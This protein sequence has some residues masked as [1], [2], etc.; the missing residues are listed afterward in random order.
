MTNGNPLVGVAAVLLLAGGA[1]A[2]SVSVPGDFATIQEAIDAAAAGDADTILISNGHYR[3]NLVLETAGI[4]LKA[5]GKKVFVD[6]AYQ[7]NV[8]EVTADD[9]TLNG[10]I[11]VNGGPDE[12]GDPPPPEGD[13]D[14]GGVLITGAGALVQRCEFR[15][16]VDFG[17][18]LVGTGTI[19]DNLIVATLGP[20]LV[21]DSGDSGGP[22]TTVEDNDILRN[23]SGVEALK[24]PFVF[25][26]NTIS[27][28]T[29][30][31]LSVSILSADGSGPG[32]DSTKIKKNQLTGNGATA[33]LLV[34]EIGSTTLIEKNNIDENGTGMD[35]SADGLTVSKND[36][37]Q[38]TMVGAWL[39]VS[40]MTWDD[41]KMRRST[42]AGAVVQTAP[43][44]T[45]GNNTF[46]DSHFQ[47]SGGDGVIVE[48]S[49]NVFDDCLFSDNQG[50]GFSIVG[51][52]AGNQVLDSQA[53]DNGH[54]GFDNSGTDTLFKDNKSKGNLGADL[55]GIGDGT[56]TVDAASA[57]NTVSDESG[58]EAEQELELDTLA[59]LP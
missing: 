57:G 14:T 26:K 49:L 13:S 20:G 27:N 54:D 4:T 47:T 56:G 36:I 11:F 42:I 46:S 52:A 40:N 16:N 22:L 24:G 6:G 35:L 48:S 53:R 39:R 18:K 15:A 5:T 2:Q 7:G 58:L 33:L 41:N 29:G 55:A 31:G 32:A 38:S 17:L 37:D 8:L 43:G 21:L 3:E 44:V 34:D 30:D 23:A 45:D 1:Y 25:E 10:I 19:E 9:V 50:D 28:N 12:G 51:G 59:T